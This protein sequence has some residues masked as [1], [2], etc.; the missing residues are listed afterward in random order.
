MLDKFNPKNE[1]AKM[2]KEELDMSVAHWQELHDQ[3]EDGAGEK[4]DPVTGLPFDNSSDDPGAPELEKIKDFDR[5]GKYKDALPPIKEM[6]NDE[7]AKFIRDWEAKNGK[8][9]N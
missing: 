1:R 7:A 6:E 8:N 9:L 2:E 5:S 3:N 4:I